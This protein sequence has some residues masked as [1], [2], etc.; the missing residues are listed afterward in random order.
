MK[1]FLLGLFLFT[2]SI[3]AFCQWGGGWVQVYKVSYSSWTGQEPEWIYAGRIRVGLSTTTQN[4]EINGSSGTIACVELVVGSITVGHLVGSFTFDSP[5][6]FNSSV[7]INANAYLNNLFGALTFKS[8]STFANMY[9]EGTDMLKYIYSDTIYSWTGASGTGKLAAAQW[10]PL[11][12]GEVGF[13]V[14]YKYWFSSMSVAGIFIDS[15]CALSPNGM[16]YLSSPTVT[17][18]A[19]QTSSDIVGVRELIIGTGDNRIKLFAGGTSLFVG[20]PGYHGTLEV[21]NAA[22]THTINFS[23]V[24]DNY[25]WIY[26]TAGNLSLDAASN[27]IWM[28]GGG[29]LKNVEFTVSS[30]TYPSG[31]KVYGMNII[32][33]GI[34]LSTGTSGEL[35][36]KISI[37]T[38]V[39]GELNYKI[40]LATG[41]TG[42]ITHKVSLST[43]VTG[44]LGYKVSLASGTANELGYKV[45]LGT[46]TSGEL[47]YKVALD[48]GTAGL[49]SKARL[50]VWYSTTAV[51][52][53]FVDTTAV[54]LIGMSFVTRIPFDAMIKG[55]HMGL[56]A[57][58]SAQVTVST[59]TVAAMTVS[60]AA[61]I[62]ATQ[63]LD[64]TSH[65]L[66][67]QQY[68]AGTWLQMVVTQQTTAKTIAI[69]IDL[70]RKQ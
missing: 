38:A 69:V 46:G 41:C 42:E 64:V 70:W 48:T 60:T 51:Y 6:T 47:G 4:I 16:I 68:N 2:C 5:V 1:R 7:T 19:I 14:P 39:T 52:A 44:E 32:G 3:P 21:L 63:S 22:E 11:S 61:T 10:I 45:A 67:G 27:I 65:S 62:T 55:W 43:G 9:S 35:N 49:L 33:D 56:D 66:I 59:G 36:Y 29:Q 13:G 37:T 50:D 26:T 30:A 8:S 54:N 20:A 15:I 24:G 58:G 57:S 17:D 12:N 40:S 34:S 23:Q 53:C 28:S 18:Y 31:Y 25:G